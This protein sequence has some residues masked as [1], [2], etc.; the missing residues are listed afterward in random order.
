MGFAIFT[1]G[2]PVNPTDGA[3]MVSAIPRTAAATAG[4]AT[5]TPPQ[6]DP[7]ST[8]FPEPSPSPTLIL[9]PVPTQLYTV[10]SGD[11]LPALAARFGVNPADIRAPQGLH[12]S[13]TLEEGQLLVIPRV[14]AAERLGPGD[15]LIPDSELVFSGGGAGFDPAQFAAQAGGY[16]AQY[17]WFVEGVN[18]VGGDLLLLA[19]EN[20]SINPRL[21]MALLE[22]QSGWATHPQPEGDALTY[23]LGYVHAYRQD[24][25]SQLSWA[26]S[27]LAIGYYG[28]RAGTL[29]ELRFADS[30]A[31][32]LD[33]TL[34]AG[35]VALQYFFM[36]K[37]NR[38]QW[39]KAIS[40]NGFVATYRQFFGDPLT[41]AVDPLIPADLTQPPLALPFTPGH[42]WY[43]SGGPHGAWENGGALAA[44]DFAP[45]SFEGGCANSLEWVT[46]MAAGKVVRS[47]YGSVL[48]DL[49]G[50]G[51]EA[52]GWV[53]LYL[54]I[55]DKDR[56][57][58]GQF[59]ETGDRLGHP[60]CQGGHATGTH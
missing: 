60:S 24:L 27:Q 48:L 3:A 4:A 14:L 9:T 7:T 44:L 56:V 41:H 55:A 45:A 1:F 21:L 17:K 43:L 53:I 6:L 25:Y 36:Q 31:L 13:A 35:T 8:L 30:S 29:T 46:A 19:A 15:K 16:L 34:N 42:T 52:T 26:A 47:D 23:P 10:Q 54:H 39:D 50:D 40:P 57:K 22:Y 49:D 11:T 28:W 38:P 18:R 20:H 12:S 51:R 33:P 59:V 5:A 32:R 37:L 2:H 58:A